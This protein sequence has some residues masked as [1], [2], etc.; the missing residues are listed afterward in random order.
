MAPDLAGLEPGDCGPAV[1]WTLIILA[2]RM[3]SGGGMEDI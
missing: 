2:G 3:L 1:R